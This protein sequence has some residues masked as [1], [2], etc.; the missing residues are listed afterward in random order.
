MF[1]TL[2]KCLSSAKIQ[3]EP[4]DKGCWAGFLS[5]GHV[6]GKGAKGLGRQ[7]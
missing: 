6:R 4:N 7:P 1:L 2:G 3:K 5:G